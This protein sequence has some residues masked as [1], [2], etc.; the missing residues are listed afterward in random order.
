MWSVSRWL[1]TISL[2]KRFALDS[3]YR[4]QYRAVP[5]TKW[6]TPDCYVLLSQ[7]AS[8]SCERDT[9]WTLSHTSIYLCVSDHYHS[10]F[11]TALGVPNMRVFTSALHSCLEYHTTFQGSQVACVIVVFMS[12]QRAVMWVGFVD[13]LCPHFSRSFTYHRA[14]SQFIQQLQTLLLI[15]SYRATTLAIWP[16]N[17]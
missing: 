11:Y 14:L 13:S 12:L 5:H 6:A 7:L 10:R 4:Q 3:L 9:T 16:I 17:T 1:I 2:R 15:R 8:S